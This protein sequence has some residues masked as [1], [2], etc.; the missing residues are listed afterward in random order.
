MQNSAAFLGCRTV[1]VDSICKKIIPGAEKGAVL[2][3]VQSMSQILFYLSLKAL[4]RKK[5][6]WMNEQRLFTP[7]RASM[8]YQRNNSIKVECGHFHFKVFLLKYRCSVTQNMKFTKAAASL[9][10]LP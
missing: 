7:D 5:E 9:K 3:T 10:I 1:I 6:C 4:G 8:S 2:A